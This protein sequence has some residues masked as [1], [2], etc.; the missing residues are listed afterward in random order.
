MKK[1]YYYFFNY[2]NKVKII[3]Y[4]KFKCL[5]KSIRRYNLRKNLPS[6][7]QFDFSSKPNS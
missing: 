3:H 5:K 1:N 6:K 7:S 4:T 2:K